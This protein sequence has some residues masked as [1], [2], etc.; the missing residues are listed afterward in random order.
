MIPANPPRRL[1]AFGIIRRPDARTKTDGRRV[2]AW[3]VPGSGWYAG[4]TFSV[5]L[6]GETVGPFLTYSAAVSAVEVE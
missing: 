3:L 5:P 1:A 4:R 6:P 2:R